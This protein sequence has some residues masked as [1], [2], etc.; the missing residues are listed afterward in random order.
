[1]RGIKGIIGGM[2][3][4]DPAFCRRLREARRDA[5]LS[6]SVV[7]AEVGCKQSALSMFEQGDGTKLNDETI[8]KLCKKF[9]LDF[10]HSEPS[11]G[12]AYDASWASALPSR[13]LSGTGFCPNPA[14][15]SHT[16]YVVEGK[17]FLIPDRKRQDPAGGKFCAVCG[18]VLERKCPECGAD[19]HDGAVCTFCGK[20]YVAADVFA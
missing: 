15:P 6:Q 9:G 19:V 8:A 17:P 3:R 13:A 4:L 14:C 18:E 16:K 20:R 10:P 12:V 2:T 11:G 5:G 7:A 1:M